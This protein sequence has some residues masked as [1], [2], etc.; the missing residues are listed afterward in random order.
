MPKSA[1]E[2]EL[3]SREFW[4]FIG[5][6]ILL[7]SAFHI[8]FITSAPVYNKLIG[9]EGLL[10]LWDTE[11]APPLDPIKTY[12][13]YQVPFAIIITILIGIGQLLTYR[14]TSRKMFSRRL[15]RSLI[16]TLAITLFLS[17][18]YDFW[19]EY[20]YLTLLFTGIFAAIS[21]LDYW[22]LIGKGKFTLSGSSIAH[23]GF[24]FVIVGALV[25]NGKQNIV[26]N[27]NV[28]LSKDLPS[29]ENALLELNDTTDLDIYKAIWTGMEEGERSIKYYDVSYY[30][31]T[32]NGLQKEFDLRPFVQMADGMGATANPS[33][34]H[35][36]NKD[37]YTH[38]VYS[39]DLEPQTEDGYGSEMEVKMGKGDTVIYQQHFVIMDSL[40]VRAAF[41][42]T[43]GQIA[44]LRM[45][46]KLTIVNVLGEEYIA[47]PV[48][49]LE[50][51]V[52]THEDAFLE[53][54][55]FKFQL[56]DPDLET[57]NSQ[58]VKIKAWTKKQE[59]KPF[60]IMKA[61]IFP[62]INLLWLGCVLMAIGTGI[63]V[64]QRV[65]RARKLKA[66]ES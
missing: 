36:W 52:L 17:Y 22:L 48:Y 61:I 15:V 29:S 42:E 12:H 65:S 25:S 57:P 56:S 1:K 53:K 41:N 59:E 20:S 16:I 23:I 2:D 33:T 6:L 28:F 4:M 8:I 64:W 35:Y 45:S 7:I 10:P 47:R 38:V 63:A 58:K 40:K 50:G 34:K 19:Q 66:T 24:A 51:N 14:K 49:N 3:S 32:E 39:S 54:Q 31:E 9:P 46:A 18:I 27:T 11:W 60:I 44:R 5:S 30:T 37:I 62:L 21:N 13:K 26:S 43:N 55:Q